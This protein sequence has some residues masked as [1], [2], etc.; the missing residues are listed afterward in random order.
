MPITHTSAR[1]PDYDFGA[2]STQCLTISGNQQPNCRAQ[3]G[4]RRARF[5]V[6]Q[7]KADADALIIIEEAR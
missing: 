7:V 4:F 3:A 6:E 5:Y 1:R 2:T